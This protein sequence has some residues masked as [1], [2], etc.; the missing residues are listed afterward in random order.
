MKTLLLQVLA[1]I[2]APIA[3]LF[4]RY[5]VLSVVP[6][7]KA[8]LAI[9]PASTTNGATQTGNIDTLGYDHVSI[10]VIATT[11][12]VVSNKFSV[13]K[14]SHSDTTN[15][16]DFSDITKFVGGGAGGFTVASADT[17]AAYIVKFNVDAR[18][19]KRYLKVTVSPRTTQTIA[20]VANLQR[21]EQTPTSATNA[22]VNTLVEG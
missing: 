6:G 9:S 2:L 18:T 5:A 8:V 22:N 13:C 20:A 17:S 10:D 16:T 12:D 4:E 19:L 21:G 3:A 11:A 1:A 14:L 15:A 7:P